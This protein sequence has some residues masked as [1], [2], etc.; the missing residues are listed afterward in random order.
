MG[1]KFFGGKFS[2]GLS[3]APLF[4]VLV[5]WIIAM[6]AHD[7]TVKIIAGGGI[8]KKK[9]I[10]C[11]AQFSIVHGIALGSVAILRPW[12][13]QGLIRHGN[14]LFSQKK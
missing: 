2:G 4:P 5:D 3:G 7:S 14:K 6:E 13:L 10:D 8:M 1:G 11:L 9:D 12:R